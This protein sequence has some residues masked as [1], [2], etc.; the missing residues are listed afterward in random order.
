MLLYSD[1]EFQPLSQ[2]SRNGAFSLKRLSE[3]GLT[4]GLLY[5]GPWKICEERLW[6]QASL[7]IRA[8]LENLESICLPGLLRE[9]DSISGFLSWT[10][11]TSTF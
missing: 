6:V 4:G 8:A 2:G 10:Q 1:C 5:W 7:S 9:K 11:R 3:E